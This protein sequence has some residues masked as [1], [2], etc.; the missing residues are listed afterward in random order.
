M[1]GVEDDIKAFGSN[2]S[3]ALKL[4]INIAIL[5]VEEI[6]ESKE[7]P[8]RDDGS[9]TAEISIQKLDM[10][11]ELLEKAKK[12]RLPWEVDYSKIKHET[13]K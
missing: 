7:I 1:F 6:I 5:L 4:T 12:L 11:K 3:E 13:I 9:Y 2:H 10:I 8:H